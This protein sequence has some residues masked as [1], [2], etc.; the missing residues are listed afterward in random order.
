MRKLGPDFLKFAFQF[1]QAADP[2]VKLYYNDYGVESI[3]LKATRT[4]NLV[5]WLRSQGAT[6]HGIGLQWHIDF[7]RSIVRDDGHYQSA[8]QFINNQLDISVT[9][10]DVTIPTNGGYLI[11]RADPYKQAIVYRA[12]LEYAIYFYPKCEALL[13][14]GFTDRYSWLQEYYKK[15]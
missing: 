5:N 4:L 2:N 12:M 14:W 11:D 9:E 3:G 7:S 15:Q 1:A 10:L 6:I 8:P 13:T